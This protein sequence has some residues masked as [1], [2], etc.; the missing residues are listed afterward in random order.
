M[1]E[2]RGEREAKPS[3]ATVHD[4]SKQTAQISVSSEEVAED[5][6]PHSLQRMIK[7]YAQ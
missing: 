5:C 6:N 4:L 7:E 1:R 2:G 3:A